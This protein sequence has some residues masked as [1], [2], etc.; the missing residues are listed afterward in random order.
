[1]TA[2]SA[3]PMPEPIE[4]E[5]SLD[6]LA[7]DPVVATLVV[8]A[9]T[10]LAAQLKRDGRP[11]PN[12]LIAFRDKVADSSRQ[13]LRGPE[14]SEIA[15]AKTTANSEAMRTIDYLTRADVMCRFGISESTVKR[16][17]RS[18]EVHFGRTVRYLAADLDGI[19]A[20]TQ[21]EG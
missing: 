6:N 20:K 11:I 16:R 10:R 4:P 18:A 12:G 2:V 19:A 3:Q 14:G 7:A 1:M 13:V 9:L 5:P 17:F 8:V 15:H 21:Q